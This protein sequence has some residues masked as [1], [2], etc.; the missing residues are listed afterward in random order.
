MSVPTVSRPT[1]GRMRFRLAR[2]PSLFWLA[3]LVLA[4]AT[5]LSVARFV[6]DA[7]AE[8][9]RWGKVRPTLVATVDLEPGAVLGPGDARV[10]ARPLALVPSGALAGQSEGQTVVDAIAEGEPVLATRLAPAGSSALAAALPAGTVGIAVPT[11][12]GALAL[13]PGDAVDVL[14]TVH[15]D[16][17]G[18]DEPTFPV[19]RSAVVV[20]VGEEAVTLAVSDTEAPR[21]AFALTAGV[22]TLVLT[23]SR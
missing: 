9:A 11:G 4:V 14:V 15:P 20:E 16:S 5:G 1:V 2:R 22:V 3:A 8:A 12:A 7:R 19:A 23:A 21:V 18:S 13:T 17:L 10:E 6:G